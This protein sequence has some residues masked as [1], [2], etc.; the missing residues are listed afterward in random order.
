MIA[1]A[2][3]SF[4]VCVLFPFFQ[5]TQYVSSKLVPMEPAI[6]P[7]RSVMGKWIAET[8]LMNSTAVSNMVKLV[9]TGQLCTFLLKFVFSE[10]MLVA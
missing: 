8:P 9:Y 7:V 2:T 6:I 3:S 1:K 10:F 5:D 4:K